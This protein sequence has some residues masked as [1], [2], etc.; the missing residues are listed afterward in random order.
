MACH[1]GTRTVAHVRESDAIPADSPEDVAY[2]SPFANRVAI[3]GALT[4][5]PCAR[6][7][8][9]EMTGASKT[10]PDRIVSEL[11]DRS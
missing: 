5:G 1:F 2:L 11:E 4:S 9:T 6:R 3:L 8:L 10:T 7:D